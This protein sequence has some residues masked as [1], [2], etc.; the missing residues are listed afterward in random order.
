MTVHSNEYIVI[1]ILILFLLLLI[2]I[3]YITSSPSSSSY[4]YK[5]KDEWARVVLETGLYA[6]YPQPT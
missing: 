6:Y 5:V 4:L 3:T 2:I 1:I